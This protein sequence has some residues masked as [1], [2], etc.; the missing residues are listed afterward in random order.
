MAEAEQKVIVGIFEDRRAVVSTMDALLKAGFNEEQLGFVARTPDEHVEQ[1]RQHVQHGHG[2]KA[3]ARGIIGGLLGAADILLVPFIGPADA[4]NIFASVLPVTE[5][6]LDHL[7]YP[8]SKH[9][10]EPVQRPDEALR[11]NEAPADSVAE[12]LPVTP[13]ENAAERPIEERSAE[14]DERTSVIAGGVIGGALG[15]AAAALFL[16]G[17]GPIVAGG[18]IASALGGGAVGSVAGS[19]LGTLTDLGIP[20]EH[21]HHYTEDIKSGRTIV[22]VQDSARREEAI[23]ILRQHGALDVHVH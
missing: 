15:A 8:D 6:A 22:T 23:Q 9:D 16:P 2:P 5:E 1:A 18:I 4:T 10:H 21:A 7:P 20:R 12:P 14:H 3:V 19:F 13:A 11:T 17:I